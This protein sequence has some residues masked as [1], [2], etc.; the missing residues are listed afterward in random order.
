MDQDREERIRK[1]AYEIWEREGRQEGSHEAHWS[2]A[3]EEL[4]AE[5]PAEGAQDETN[6]GEPASS[7]ETG[8]D[9]APAIAGDEKPGPE[10]SPAQVRPAGKESVAD[11]PEE[12]TEQ[13]EAS[14][15]SFPASDPATK[16]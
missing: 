12:W 13:D 4:R 16:Y 10:D 1:R 5:E 7:G 15:E 3:Q 2:Q 11:K 14:D 6:V 9:K 8:T